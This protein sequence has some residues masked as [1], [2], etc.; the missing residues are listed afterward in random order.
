MDQIFGMV[1]HQ[2]K[3]FKNWKFSIGGSPTNRPS[4]IQ[5]F[6]PLELL[7]QNCKGK[8][9]KDKILVYVNG[10]SPLNGAAKI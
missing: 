4:K 6:Q 7:T 1:R 2:K 3:Y 5:T 10:G 9:R 8:Y